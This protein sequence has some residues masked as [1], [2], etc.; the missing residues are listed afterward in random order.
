NSPD[1]ALHTSLQVIIPIVLATAAFF[2]IGAWL[3]V[4]SHG[5]KVVT[6]AAGLVGQRGDARTA[7]TKDGGRVFVAGTHWSAVA[8][9]DI[10]QGAKVTVTGVQGMTLKVERQD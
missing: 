3:S 8:D 5:R 9:A 1:P 6:G 4:R 7:V 2:A 10:P